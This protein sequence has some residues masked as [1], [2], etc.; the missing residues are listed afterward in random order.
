MT[1]DDEESAFEAALP[2]KHMDEYRA[3]RREKQRQGVP[4]NEMNAEFAGYADLP[5]LA[6]KPAEAEAYRRGQRRTISS[7]L[8]A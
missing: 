4:M 5:N 1:S 7:Q 6:E 2:D 8:T 3:F